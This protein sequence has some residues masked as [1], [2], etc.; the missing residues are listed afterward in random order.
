MEANRVFAGDVVEDCTSRSDGTEGV[1]E[2]DASS[3]GS[4]SAI[5]GT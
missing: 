1:L 3:T 5:G 2:M 4:E